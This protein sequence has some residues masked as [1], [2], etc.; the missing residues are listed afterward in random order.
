VTGYIW[1]RYPNAIDDDIK[2]K[3]GEVG[4]ILPE[5]I[6]ATVPKEVYRIQYENEEL[7]GWYDD[8]HYDNPLTTVIIPLITKLSGC[9]CGLKTFPIISYLSPT[10][11]HT[12]LPV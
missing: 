9:V 8:R 3:I 6:D 7:I 2:P 4:F 5:Q 12:T 1:Q 11:M 10:I